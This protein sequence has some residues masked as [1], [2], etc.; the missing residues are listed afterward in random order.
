MASENMGSGGSTTI[1]RRILPRTTGSVSRRESRSRRRA[2]REK[3]RAD[4]RSR[5]RCLSR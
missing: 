5:T 4:S 1:T 3:R 2:L